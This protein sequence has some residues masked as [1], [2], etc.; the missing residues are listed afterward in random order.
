VRAYVA[1]LTLIGDLIINV[2]GVFSAPLAT[3]QVNDLT[4]HRI[5]SSSV[6]SLAAATVLIEVTKSSSPLA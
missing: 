6:V 3:V 5:M 4:I 1:D 2:G